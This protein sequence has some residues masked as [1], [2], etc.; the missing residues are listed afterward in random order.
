MPKYIYR[1]LN[2]KEQIVEGVVTAPSEERAADILLDKNFIILSLKRKAGESGI[3]ST[4]FFQRVSMKEIVVFA[5]QLSILISANIPLVQ[6]LKILLRQTTDK[7]MKIIIS[8]L[9]SDVEGGMKFSLALSKHQYV[10]DNFFVNIIKSG[11]TSGKLDEVLL[12]MADQMEKD[13]DLI[14]RIRGAM[15]YPAFIISGLIIVG[16]I[17]LI[18]VIPKITGILEEAG[19]ELPFSTRLLI[20]TSSFFSNYWWLLLIVFFS[21][22]FIIR[23]FVKTQSG[24]FAWDLA[25]IRFP[26]VGGLMKK[27]AI[28]RF[29]R[30][31]NT[32]ISGGV[33]LPQ[34]FK[35]VSEVVGNVVYKKL[36]LDTVKDIEG[37]N[38]IAS[39][40]TES[41]HVPLMVSQMM[42]VGE[43]TGRLDVILDKISVFYSREIDNTLQSLVTLIEPIV[44]VIIGVAVGLMIAA[45]ILPLYNLSS[46]I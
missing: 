5:R 17:M 13:Y 27:I 30:S 31:L 7:R 11:E 14:S 42:N 3:L 8:E 32:L 45:V 9:V 29:A 2:S 41:P 16:M 28:V 39:V 22:L 4:W 38:P 34:G 10:F 24:R 40:F 37:G 25:K 21:L 19:V 44:M 15:I 36:I 43:K 46:A 12:Y 18:F 35:I 26:I 20:G 6:G 33:S 23:V 1:T